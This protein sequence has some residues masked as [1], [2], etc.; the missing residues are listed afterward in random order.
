MIPEEYESILLRSLTGTASPEEENLLEVWKN[1]SAANQKVFD[2]YQ[3]LF[4]TQEVAGD[5]DFDSVREWNKLTDAIGNLERT[6]HTLSNNWVYRIAATIVLI[7]AST[8]LIREMV[9]EHEIIHISGD[10]IL[11]LK[12]HDGSSII[13]KENSILTHSTSFNRNDRNVSLTGEAYFEVMTNKE[14]PF[15]IHA[16]KS[17][18]EVLGTKFMVV[19]DPKKMENTVE[20]KEGLVSFTYDDSRKTVNV[21]AG[22]KAIL[23]KRL[24]SITKKRTSGEN[25]LA[26]KERKLIFRKTPLADI[27]DVVES[28]FDV[29][30]QVS[31]ESLMPCRFTG[32]FDDPKIDEVLEALS[33]SLNVDVLFRDGS[34]QIQGEGC[35]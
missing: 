17:S 30:I 35:K 13:L 19:A 22:E 31:D 20:V 9:K 8:F 1:S 11:T 28:Y 10:R 3:K 27:V 6:K 34:Y 32:T 29:E 24:Q 25:I 14:K 18:I 16:D 15:I 5:P 21:G 12:L 33:V 23:D 26:W 7:I 4:K 2:D